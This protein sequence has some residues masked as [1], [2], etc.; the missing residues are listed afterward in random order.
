MHP[1]VLDATGYTL[2][3]SSFIA[4]VILLWKG[5]SK[6]CKKKSPFYALS[7]SDVFT[8]VSTA[9]IL[10]GSRIETGMRLNYN[11]QNNISDTLP[12]HAWS[13]E[14]NRFPFLQIHEVF[15][16]IDR[17]V[18]LTCGTKDIF[19]QYGMLLAALTNAFISLLT[20]IVQ[21]NLNAAYIKK[22]CANVVK[23]LRN[24]QLK[25]KSTEVKCQESEIFKSEQ[26]L[27][28]LP[29]GDID[30][31]TRSNIVRK[32]V[33]ISKFRTL[34]DNR[35]STGFLVTSHWL[36]PF[37]VVGILHF[38]EYGD[39][40]DIGHTE[41]I[42]C[43]LESNFPMNTFDMLS[44]TDDNS[45]IISSIA[46]VTPSDTYFFNEKLSNE[47]E[48]NGE[49]DEIVSKVQTIVRTAL[50]YKDNSTKDIG[51]INFLRTTSGPQNLT[52]YILT[53][54]IMKYIKDITNISSIVRELN[55]TER[56]INSHNSSTNN[57]MY[58]NKDSEVSLIYDMLKNTSEELHAITSGNRSNI[59][60]VSVRNENDNYQ[61]D[62][63]IHF[64][65]TEES[66]AQMPLNTTFVQNAT[67]ISNNQI[68]DMILK[69]IQ[70]ASGHSAAK[71]HYDRSASHL[72]NGDQFKI[73]NLKNYIAKR[74]SNS[75]KNLFSD[76]NN[77]RY[78]NV[79]TKQSSSLH[80][81]NECL[82]ST[83]FLK[84]HL[85]VLSFVV[86]F[87]PI[88]FSCILQVR[89]KY[90]CENTLAILKTKIDLPST[91]SKKIHRQD[92][93]D[94]SST[95]QRLRNDRSETDIDAIE[96]DHETCRENESIALEIDCMIRIFDTIKL[97]LIL[98]VVLWTPIFLE[99]LLKVYSCIHIPQWLTDTTFLSAC[100]FG[101]VRNALNI[102][103]IRIQEV[104][105][106]GTMKENKIR[107][108]E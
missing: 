100:S 59:S 42:A 32:I 53:N 72:K 19:M 76:K 28:S 38:A 13:I 65:N 44:D 22:R 4:L 40:N 6:G 87:L 103:I 5:C 29:Q 96:K 90:V 52:K 17:N 55:E 70:A 34:K 102:N 61:E 25:L 46:Y 43:I 75:M 12:N 86:Y 30:T 64:A 108:I 68:Y 11:W 98:C 107:P 82:V 74:K 23:S 73:N 106:E 85:F 48:P 57:N 3:S 15:D 8:G 14:D 60:R 35:K 58:L 20:F 77:N 66:T 91:S 80:M 33:K 47:S 18:T 56:D 36:V 37:L 69:R 92:S 21:C 49:V 2:L 99:I 51:I 71:N 101:I 7:A 31:K 95:S 88:L 93:V 63:Q 54:N 10:L 26:E 84:L 9:I 83:K 1:T 41:D 105:S 62:A 39:M 78:I 81:T 97:S 104:C 94:E 16:E 67:F 79:K 24:T 45:N 27:A 89:G 50:S